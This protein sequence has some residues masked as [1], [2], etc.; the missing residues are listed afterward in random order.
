M[1]VDILRVRKGNQEKLLDGV[2]QNID[3]RSQIS[4]GAGKKPFLPF[5]SPTVVANQPSMDKFVK[6]TKSAPS[7]RVS[8]E[9]EK[10]K[11]RFNPYSAKVSEG[12]KARQDWIAIGKEQ[13]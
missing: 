1:R 10:Q 9:K 11:L 8:S 7:G 12:D 5:L 13:K 6:I 4:G 3:L 2:F